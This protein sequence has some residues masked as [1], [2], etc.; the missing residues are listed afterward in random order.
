MNKKD[1]EGGFLIPKKEMPKF[2]RKSHAFARNFLGIF[3]SATIITATRQFAEI[4]HMLAAHIA[5]YGGNTDV[6]RGKAAEVA[7]TTCMSL[8][9]AVS[10]V[11]S[12]DK[13]I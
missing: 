5:M 7:K 10:K 9:E 6:L 2:L 11:I 8:E 12:D 3:G 4:E 1:I 13:K